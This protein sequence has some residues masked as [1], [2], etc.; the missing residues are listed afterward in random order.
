MAFVLGLSALVRIMYT[1]LLFSSL[2]DYRLVCMR[3]LFP[4]HAMGIMWSA[5]RA[6]LL[7]PTYTSSK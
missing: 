3:G 4:C 1:D 2:E 7:L 6:L 5:R